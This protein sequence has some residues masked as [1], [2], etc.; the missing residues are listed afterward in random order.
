MPLSA[1]RTTHGEST[2]AGSRAASIFSRAIASLRGGAPH[3]DNLHQHYR[4]PVFELGGDVTRPL[5]G[6]ALK[7]V[8]LETRRKRHDLD[9]YVQRDGLIEDDARVNGGS[10]QLIV[11]NATNPSDGSAGLGPACSV[12]HSRPEPR[13]R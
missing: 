9:Q 12:C 3:D 8:A 10:E 1:G 4:D 5:A 2:R 13:L 6:G 11:A 7:F